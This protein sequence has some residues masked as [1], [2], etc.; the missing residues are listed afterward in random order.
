[1]K[2]RVTLRLQTGNRF[3]GR[4][5]KETL[6]TTKECVIIT[7]TDFTNKTADFKWRL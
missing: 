3:V 4:V 7:G 2:F 5:G 6:Q 1:M